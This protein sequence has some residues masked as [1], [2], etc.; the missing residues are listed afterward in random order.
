MAI[1]ANYTRGQRPTVAEMNT[2]AANPALQYITTV[3]INAVTT[4][5]S[6]CFSS[7]YDNYHLEWSG[8]YSP[9]GATYALMSLTGGAGTAHYDGQRQTDVTGTVTLNSQNGT[10]YWLGLIIDNTLAKSTQ[11]TMDIF[12]PY[13]A[14]STA[15]TSRSNYGLGGVFQGGINTNNTSYTGFSIVGLFGFTIVGTLRIYGYRKA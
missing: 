8:V 1:K 15:Y 10:G 13:V 3:S 2:Y 4:T 6:N 9:T 7:T 5:V 14:A 12:N 11:A